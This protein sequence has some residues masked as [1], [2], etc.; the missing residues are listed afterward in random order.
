MSTI[1]TPKIPD[2]TWKCSNCGNTIQVRIPPQTCPV[3]TKKCEFLN[4]TCY[5]PDCGFTGMDNRLK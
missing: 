2:N 4:V 5:Q 3:C 1:S